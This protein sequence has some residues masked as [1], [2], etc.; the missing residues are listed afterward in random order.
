MYH[1]FQYQVIPGLLTIK[2][3]YHWTLTK[4]VIAGA[5]IVIGLLIL[6]RFGAP[7]LDHVV[8]YNP[9]LNRRAKSEPPLQ[10]RDPYN[11]LHE[12]DKFIPTR[13]RRKRLTKQQKG[14]VLQQYNHRCGMCHKRLESFDTE[15][16]HIIPLAADP[17]G[18]RSDLNDTHNFRPLCRRCHGYTSFRQRKAGMFAHRKRRFTR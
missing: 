5:L 13:H 10:K 3:S 6:K 2:S 4:L 7:N 16:D 9:D 14:Q 11:P 15:M 8:D 18:L 12:S 1:P 17:F